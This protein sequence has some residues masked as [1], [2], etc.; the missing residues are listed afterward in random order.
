MIIRFHDCVVDGSARSL[1]RAGAPA[2][3]TPKAFD[4]LWLLISERPRVVDKGELFDRVWPG[5]FVTDAS[6]SRTIHEIRDAL[7]DSAVA[8]RTVHGRGYAFD[9][10]AVDLVG[11]RNPAPA[12][13]IVRAWLLI[14][15]RAVALRDGETLIGRD[16]SVGA[17]LEPLLTSW[18]HARLRVTEDMVTIEDLRSKNGT[19]LR[20]Q[21]LS[22]AEVLRDGDE[23][24]IGATRIIFRSGEKML[25]TATDVRG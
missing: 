22:A 1:V 5:T 8:I 2:H 9:A 20:G 23:I 3:L 11:G 10:E 13:P 4:V 18:H 24:V 14:G 21:R 16:P 6:L 17:P 7:G 25:P 12:A 19:T 15:A